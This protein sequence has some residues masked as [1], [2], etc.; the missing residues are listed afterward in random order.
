MAGD[1]IKMR[2]DLHRHPKV[3]LMAEFLENQDG[4][5]AAQASQDCRRHVG[6][7][8]SALRC[9]TVGALC[10][11][12]GATRWRGKRI[13][14]DLFV[15]QMTVRIIDEIS[16][17]PGFGKAMEFVGWVRQEHEGLFFPRFFEEMNSDPAETARSK[18]AERQRR[19]RERLKQQQEYNSGATVAPQRGAREEKRR[20]ENKE[21]EKK[22]KEPKSASRKR[23]EYSLDFEAFW[24]AYPQA[25]RSGKAKAFESWNRKTKEV[26]PQIIIAAAAE[27]A[28][29]SKVASGYAKHAATWLNEKCWEDDRAAWG[30]GKPKQRCATPEEMAGWTPNQIN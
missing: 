29:C 12:W 20:E 4:E 5:L 1:W 18:K 24:N 21:K 7:T 2:T 9:A 23:H 30:A 10:A 16:G 25:G 13:E 15:P 27:Y 17:M 26:D 19:Y 6:A 8:R 22:E 11:T 3:C 14:D 28:Q